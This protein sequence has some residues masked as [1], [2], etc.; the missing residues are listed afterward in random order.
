MHIDEGETTLL[1]LR[2]LVGF[3]QYAVHKNPIKFY[4]DIKFYLWCNFHLKEKKVTS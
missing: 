2:I 4:A 1:V 3:R